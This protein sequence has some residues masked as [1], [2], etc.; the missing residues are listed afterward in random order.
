MTQVTINTNHLRDFDL[1]TLDSFER[2]QY[3]FLRLENNKTKALQII[4]N[5][6]EGDYTQLSEGLALIAEEMEN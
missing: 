4:I 3:S 1:D 6:V 2:M 5:S